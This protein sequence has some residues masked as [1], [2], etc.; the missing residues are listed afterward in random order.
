MK[1]QVFKPRCSTK[2]Y[3]EE[4][5]LPN[6]PV[7][8][9]QL[10]AFSLAPKD[11]GSLQALSTARESSSNFAGACS[12]SCSTRLLKSL[13]STACPHKHKSL[14]YIASPLTLNIKEHT[15]Y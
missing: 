7:L 14:F 2:N 13:Y 12:L 15:F 6:T 10:Q 5:N 4:G 8:L 9:A 3:Q 11:P 1:K